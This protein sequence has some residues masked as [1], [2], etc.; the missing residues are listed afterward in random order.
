MDHKAIADRLKATL[1]A[2]LLGETSTVTPRGGNH[3][4]VR[5]IHIPANEIAVLLGALDDAAAEVN[6]AD[7][8]GA[9]AR[10]CAARWQRPITF[11]G[12]D[13]Y[14]VGDLFEVAEAPGED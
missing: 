7:V 10:E 13:F 2:A 3:V 14:A 6:R 8:L 5:Y 4:H 12:V 1:G 11:L 9:R